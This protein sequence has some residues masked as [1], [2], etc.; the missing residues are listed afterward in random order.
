MKNYFVFKNIDS[1]DFEIHLA[2]YPPEIMPQKRVLSITIPGRSGTLHQKEGDNI[3]ESYYRP[4]D[5]TALNFNY[6]NQIKK[7]LNGRGELIFGNRPDLVCDAYFSTQV[8]FNRIFKQWRRANISPEIQPF[9]LLRKFKEINIENHISENTFYVQTEFDC[10][11]IMT[12]MPTSAESNIVINLNGLKLQIT[13]VNDKQII[14]NTDLQVIYSEDGY[15][16]MPTSICPNWPLKLAVGNN[17]ISSVNVKKINI[18]HRGA[19]L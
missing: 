9:R 10:P 11:F 8:E 6:I 4:F 17:Q 12:I 13:P 18:K 15:N 2:E 3:F 14:I 19:F 7:W 16:L 5:I 1:R